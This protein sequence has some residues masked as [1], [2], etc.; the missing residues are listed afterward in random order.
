MKLPAVVW[1]S[2][3]PMLLGLVLIPIMMKS[4]THFFRLHLLFVAFMALLAG[5]CSSLTPSDPQIASPSQPVRSEFRRPADDKPFFFFDS[6]AQ[7]IEAS[8]G[9]AGMDDLSASSR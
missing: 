2:P 5:G 7:D 8:L 4:K 9:V 6:K 3:N 1:D